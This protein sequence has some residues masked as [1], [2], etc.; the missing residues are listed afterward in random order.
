MLLNV[1]ERGR[2]LRES[3]YTPVKKLV[4]EKTPRD[5]EAVK[6]AVDRAAEEVVEGKRGVEG[7]RG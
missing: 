6:R 7:L 2:Y 5:F 4:G 3:A 1:L